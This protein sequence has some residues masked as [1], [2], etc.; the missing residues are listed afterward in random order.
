MESK[1]S[2][3]KEAVK[4]YKTS[5]TLVPSS[6]FLANRMLKPIDFDKA[7][8]IVELGPGDGAITKVILEKLQPHTKLIC[9]EINPIFLKELEKITHPQ[10][11]LLNESAE[12]LEEHLKTF[13]FT[14]ADYIVSSLPL[15]IIPKK[16]SHS[17]LSSC[18]AV[19]KQRGLFIQYQYSLTYF[20]KLKLVFGKNITLDFETLNFPPAFVYKC[21]KK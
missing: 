10:L 4:N 2:F 19:L 15:T 11:I 3:F 6:R 20:K 9:F 1:F 12:N 8:V 18:Y 13:G 17:I 21:L 16:I 5:G 7:D 14:Q